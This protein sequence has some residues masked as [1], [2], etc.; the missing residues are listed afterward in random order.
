MTSSSVELELRAQRLALAQQ[1][2]LVA[3][4]ADDGLELAAVRRQRVGA[5]IALEVGAL[6]VDQH[7]H[8]GGVRHIAMSS[9]A[10]LSVPF[11]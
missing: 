7:G 2:G 4:T 1:I 10:R 3:H 11:A 6:R 8:R 5:A 9:A